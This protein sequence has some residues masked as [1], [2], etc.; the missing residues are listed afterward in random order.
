MEIQFPLIID[1]DIFK[2]IRDVLR[3][4]RIGEGQ[5]L[6]IGDWSTAYT[7]RRLSLC[8]LSGGSD[9]L[10]EETLRLWRRTAWRFSPSVWD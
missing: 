1:R 9:G 8:F 6:C 4:Q 3:K 2:G 5:Q 7:R 10:R